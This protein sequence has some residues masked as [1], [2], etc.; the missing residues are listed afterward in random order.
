MKIEQITHD[1]VQLAILLRKDYCE[2][3][4]QFLTGETDPLQLGYMNRPQGY[5]IRPHTHNPVERKILH[6]HEVLFI[7]SGKV[8]V[9]FYTQEKSYLRSIVVSEGDVILLAEGGH[10]FKML[11][12]SEII[13]IKQGPYVGEMDKQRFDP[14]DDDSVN[15]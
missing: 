9:D 8:R 12:E 3:G 4:I 6:T 13:E 10:G 7:K 14:I 5:V 1:N 2:K 11:E 15:D